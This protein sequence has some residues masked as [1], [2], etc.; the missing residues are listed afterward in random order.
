M[1][2]YGGNL[3]KARSLF[4]DYP[5]NT[6][7]RPVIEYMAPRTYRRKTAA[8]ISWFVGGRFAEL[9]EKVH[10]ICPPDRDPLLANRTPANRRLPLAGQAFHRARIAEVAGDTDATRQ[11]WQRFVSEWTDEK[12]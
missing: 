7:N 11:A 5:V 1:L 10:A 12:P 8:E 3:T 2:F 9:V 4:E 6:D